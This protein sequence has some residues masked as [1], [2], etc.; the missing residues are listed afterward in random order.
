MS[1]YVLSS[2]PLLSIISGTSSRSNFMSI[3]SEYI[4]FFFNV[5]ESFSIIFLGSVIAKS[6]KLSLNSDS[7]VNA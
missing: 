2:I 3:N 1:S 7:M 4:L 6:P 5:R